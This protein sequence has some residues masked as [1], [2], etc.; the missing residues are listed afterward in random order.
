VEVREVSEALVEVEAVAD[1]ELVW[2]GEADVADGEILDQAPVRAVEEG[3][4]RQ[5]R[6]PAQAQGA[7]EEVER[8]ARVDDVLDHEHVA[9]LDRGLEV[10]EQPDAA[11]AAVGGELEEVELVW[12]LERAR[13]V[14]QED[15]ARLQR[16]DQDGVGVRVVERDLGRQLANAA[17]DLL[18]REVD[19]ADATRRYDASSSLYRSARRAMS[20][21]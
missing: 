9:V 1:E 20:R 16:R 17:A 2:D 8:E 21:L 7:D 4:R 18:A 11:A 12:D 3:R 10:L 19:L 5:R 15:E 13:E 14:G 6:R